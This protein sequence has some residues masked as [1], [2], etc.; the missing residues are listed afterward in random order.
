MSYVRD[1]LEILT[2]NR[3][4]AGSHEI[5]MH[6]LDRDHECLHNVLQVILSSMKQRKLIEPDKEV[7][8]C[9]HRER[10]VWSI[11]ERGKIWLNG[12]AWARYKD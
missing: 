1:V 8:S 3:K 9:C 6:L 11:T 4:A 7:C 12:G 2:K 10:T 5:H